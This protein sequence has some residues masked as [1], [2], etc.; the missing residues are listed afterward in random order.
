MRRIKLTSSPS[1]EQEDIEQ[2]L[3][4]ALKDEQENQDKANAELQTPLDNKQGFDESAS[5]DIQAATD[6]TQAE[7]V[8]ETAS[9][10]GTT[11]EVVQSAS[12]TPVEETTV[13]DTVTDDAGTGEATDTTETDTTVL[14]NPGEDTT[15]SGTEA[16][17]AAADDSEVV[18]ETSAE[19]GGEVTDV[20]AQ[21][22]ID[23][24]AGTE[25]N[26]SITAFVA[27]MRD[28]FSAAKEQGFEGNFNDFL[29]NVTESIGTKQAELQTNALGTTEG[30][31]GVVEPESKAS[32]LDQAASAD[33][34]EV[35]EQ[36]DTVTPEVTDDATD[37]VTDE[38]VDNSDA[39][40]TTTTET[41]TTGTDAV[42]GDETTTDETDA[43]STDEATGDVTNTD[44]TETTDDVTGQEVTDTT[45][46]TTDETASSDSNDTGEA[47]TGEDNA[48]TS[49]SEGAGGTQTEEVGT[50]TTEAEETPTEAPEGSSED[51]EEAG[52]EAATAT[53]D[54]STDLDAGTSTD[55]DTNLNGETV[56]GETAEDPNASEEEAG[57]GVEDPE[58]VDDESL[59]EYIDDVDEEQDQIDDADEMVDEALDTS[60][61]LGRIAEIV[62]DAIEESQAEDGDKEEASES[63]AKIAEL[64]TESFQSF[65]GTKTARSAYFGLESFK[66]QLTPVQRYEITLESISDTV[67]KIIEAIV[68]MLD[69]MGRFMADMY[70]QAMLKFGQYDKKIKELLK[71]V[72]EIGDKTKQSDT[73]ENKR[74]A[75]ALSITG[76]VPQ[77]LDER[78]TTIGNI[79][80]DVY[81]R[82]TDWYLG[83][84]SMVLEKNKQNPGKIFAIGFPDFGKLKGMHLAPVEDPVK[85][86]FVNQD[87]KDNVSVAKSEELLGG[88]CISLILPNPEEPRHQILDLLKDENAKWA[89]REN[90][91]GFKLNDYIPN[92]ESIHDQANGKLDV[93]SPE[94]MK[95][96]LASLEFVLSN[97]KGYDGIKGKINTVRSKARVA[98]LTLNN[99]DRWNLSKS[100]LTIMAGQYRMI[101]RS[102]DEP[103]ASYTSYVLRIIAATLSYVANSLKAYGVKAEDTAPGADLV[104]AA[105]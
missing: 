39:I 30:S 89:S 97:A 57:E 35:T 95:R 26:T 76:Q 82:M 51:S 66:S 54:T 100:D 10:T 18:A 28:A 17:D 48:P 11:D 68:R 22:V 61:R 99:A 70:R 91:I 58:A 65:T 15:A 52:S 80:A 84:V 8:A 101:S 36:T 38:V 74:V 37:E 94:Q 93:L 27:K 69:N 87:L 2:Q 4:D 9:D 53:D 72:D 41:D 71:R 47:S 19:P 7:E 29:D 77:D 46:D 67:K 85:E 102:I 40:D 75:Q 42:T 60:S 34:A 90:V 78:L 79:G 16:Q 56:E 49:D 20:V 5:Q 86:G 55:A 32:E 23:N 83:E 3:K 59:N 24:G 63:L 44:T 13:T 105:A 64:A 12:D 81:G 33:A 73:I 96:V 1:L 103:L 62:K 104:P 50:D 92:D 25:E 6:A 31:G 14:D 88:K 98:T 43:V 45:T 21:S